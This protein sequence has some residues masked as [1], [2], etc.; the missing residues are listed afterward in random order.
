MTDSEGDEFEDHELPQA[1]RIIEQNK[2][3][4]KMIEEMKSKT[5]IFNKRKSENHSEDSD[6]SELP[7]YIYAGLGQN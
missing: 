7:S 6:E 5:S 4:K 3:R 1:I 2:M